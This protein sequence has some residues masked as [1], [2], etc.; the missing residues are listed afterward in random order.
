MTLLYVTLCN[1]NGLFYALCIFRENPLAC[2]YEKS[3]DIFKK[4]Q[5]SLAQNNSTT[6]KLQ[7]ETV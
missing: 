7:R 4:S 2:G 6:L 5:Q 3:R 1:A